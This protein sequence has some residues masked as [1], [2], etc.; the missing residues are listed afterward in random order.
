MLKWRAYSATGGRAIL[1]ISIW[2]FNG[3]GVNIPVPVGI[4]HN[5][6]C[7]GC[8]DYLRS[9]NVRC[10]KWW[11]EYLLYYCI[12]LAALLW[13]GNNQGR[14]P[15]QTPHRQTQLD[16]ETSVSRQAVSRKYGSTRSSTLLTLLFPTDLTRAW[17]FVELNFLNEFPERGQRLIRVQARSEES[18]S[19]YPTCENVPWL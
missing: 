18:P 8:L 13:G 12:W 11:L 16:P 5:N 14:E 15:P 10:R 19:L 7:M 4:S 9:E 6:Y 17:L 2:L 3:V 1:W